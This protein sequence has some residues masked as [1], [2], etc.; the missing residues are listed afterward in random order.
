MGV[1]TGVPGHGR[2]RR[3]CRPAGCSRV[4]A[5]A[6]QA[7]T[8]PRIE[9]TSSAVR[10]ECVQSAHPETYKAPR[11]QSTPAFGSQHMYQSSACIRS[12][13][14]V[15]SFMSESSA[16]RAP[17]DLERT[18]GDVCRG[19]DVVNAGVRVAHAASRERGKVLV[20]AR[21]R[22]GALGRRGE[23]HGAG[24][25]RLDDDAGVGG[26]GAAGA[27]RG[28]GAR[29]R[30]HGVRARRAEAAHAG[31]GVRLGRRGAGRRGGRVGC[32][33]VVSYLQCRRALQQ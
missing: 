18:S 12:G 30:R 10:F 26:G 28:V 16:F 6:H 17:S 32:A 19:A 5:H 25:V 24:A 15:L 14:T 33:V 11:M 21:P 27:G 13:G 3:R 20:L 2:A 8:S 1:C 31:G 29:R 22:A 7:H 4:P 23:R 9:C